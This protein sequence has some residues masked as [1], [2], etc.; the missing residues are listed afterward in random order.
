MPWFRI[1]YAENAFLRVLKANDWRLETLSVQQGNDAMLE[2]YREYQPQ[3]GGEDALELA[4]RGREFAITRRMTRSD[5]G[6][7]RA[8]A[9]TFTLERERSTEAIGRRLELL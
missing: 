8:L 9:L 5:D 1:A 2:F 3:H 7:T 6:T 4:W